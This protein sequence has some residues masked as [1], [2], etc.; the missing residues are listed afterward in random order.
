MCAGDRYEERASIGREGFGRKW[1]RG[2]FG[3]REMI[4]VRRVKWAN[5]LFDIEEWAGRAE[6]LVLRGNLRRWFE[7]RIIMKYTCAK[8]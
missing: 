8:F 1:P 6:L 3:D 5:A 7:W 2:I 4:H